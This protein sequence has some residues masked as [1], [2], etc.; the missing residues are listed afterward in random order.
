MLETVASKV[1]LRELVG[2]SGQAA[3]GL[4]SRVPRR[5]VE[6]EVGDKLSKYLR[7]AWRLVAPVRM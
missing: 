6:A 7:V 3:K 1:V 4:A 2:G 5:S